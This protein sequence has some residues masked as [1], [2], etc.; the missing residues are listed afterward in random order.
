MSANLAL[1]FVLVCTMS[2]DAIERATRDIGAAFQ[3]DVPA[4][5]TT[6]PVHRFRLEQKREA[7]KRGTSRGRSDRASSALTSCLVTA[8]VSERPS[9]ALSPMRGIRER[10]GWC[11]QIPCSTLGSKWC[12]RGERQSGTTSST[13]PAWRTCSS[14]QTALPHCCSVV[15]A[16]TS[17]R[18]CSPP[19]G[20]K[21]PRGAASAAVTRCR[22]RTNAATRARQRRCLCEHEGRALGTRCNRPRIRQ[23]RDRR[24]QA[25]R[26]RDSGSLQSAR[27][28]S[29]A[30]S[31]EM[32]AF[33]KKRVLACVRGVCVTSSAREFSIG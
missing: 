30:H 6:R 16:I 29:F 20:A 2:A 24:G 26:R 4:L 18:A 28:A 17:H 23:E 8:R 15:K 21:Q 33:R 14:Q 19:S 31:E 7:A 32:P 27:C 9:A 22:S 1:R 3:A 5:P 25:R 13:V 10:A 11:L 12:G